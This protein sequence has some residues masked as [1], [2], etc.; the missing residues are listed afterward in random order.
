MSVREEYGMVEREGRGE[1][2]E[3][4]RGLG[5]VLSRLRGLGRGRLTSCIH[6]ASVE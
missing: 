6:L 3:T 5:R 2:G 4:G 1:K